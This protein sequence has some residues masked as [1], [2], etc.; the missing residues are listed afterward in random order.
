MLTALINVLTAFG[1][2]LGNIVEV[3]FNQ[4]IPYT[5]MIKGLQEILLILAS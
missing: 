5:S 1:I 3:F 2:G 4:V